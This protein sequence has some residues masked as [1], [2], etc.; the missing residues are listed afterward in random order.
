MRKRRQRCKK[1]FSILFCAAGVLLPQPI[2]AI[3]YNPDKIL[4]QLEEVEIYMESYLQNTHKSLTNVDITEEIVP[5][6]LSSREDRAEIVRGFEQGQ[7]ACYVAK[8]CAWIGSL[9]PRV[10]LTRNN[11]NGRVYLEK[12]K[13]FFGSSS[14][15][16]PPQGTGVPYNRA[17]NVVWVKVPLKSKATSMKG[18]RL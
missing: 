15:K 17:D 18:N 12:R 9:L 13:V 8:D 5:Y 11:D 3:E 16:S 10:F 4:L 2:E 14:L 1:F 6:F 7:Y